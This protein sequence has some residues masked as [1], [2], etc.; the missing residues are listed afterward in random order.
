M[1]LP[2]CGLLT[3]LCFLAKNWLFCRT[4]IFSAT[5]L[6]ILVPQSWKERRGQETRLEERRDEAGEEKG[7][8]REEERRR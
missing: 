3:K 2:K 6:E 5:K 7:E 8:S 1:F 4:L